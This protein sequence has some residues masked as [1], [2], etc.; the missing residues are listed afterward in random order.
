MPTAAAIKPHIKGAALIAVC[1]P[2]NPTGTTF[3]KEL[4]EIC[5]LIVEENENRSADE[6]KQVLN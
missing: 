5:E 1:S 2:L 3:T 4:E 6:K